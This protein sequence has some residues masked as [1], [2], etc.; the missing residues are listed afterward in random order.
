MTTAYPLLSERDSHAVVGMDVARAF[1][2]PGN[3]NRDNMTLRRLAY[4]VRQYDHL[5]ALVD[6]HD[7]QDPAINVLAALFSSK[8]WSRLGRSRTGGES[9]QVRRARD[10]V[11]PEARV[12]AR[13]ALQSGN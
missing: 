1:L 10:S 9:V 11:A 4:A 2:W 13:I 6:Q 5:Q 12:R 3:W 8:D 7:E